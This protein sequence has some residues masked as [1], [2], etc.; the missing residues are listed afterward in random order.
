[1]SANLDRAR[2]GSSIVSSE[3]TTCDGSTGSRVSAVG[4]RELATRAARFA[5]PGGS[6]PSESGSGDPDGVATDPVVGSFGGTQPESCRQSV[7]P[8]WPGRY[9]AF[10]EPLAA[11]LETVGLGE[12]RIPYTLAPPVSA[13]VAARVWDVAPDGTTLLLTRGAARLDPPAYDEPEG[14]LRLGLFGNH[15]RVPA[16]HRL[17]VDLAQVDELM[18]RRA[19]PPATL[20]FSGAELV[21]PAR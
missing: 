7:T 20:S 10:T 21:L 8:D 15:W 6:L 4:P 5:L 12:V 16:G 18:W 1:V 3:Q 19:N 11:P 14:E 9:T 2:E 17:R 13:A